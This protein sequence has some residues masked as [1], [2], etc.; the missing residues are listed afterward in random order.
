MPARSRCIGR[1][2][3]TT[4]RSLIYLGTVRDGYKP[5]TIFEKPAFSTLADV[6]TDSCVRA[7]DWNLI[8]ACSDFDVEATVFKLNYFDTL[9]K[10]VSMFICDDTNK[11]R[12]IR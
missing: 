7:I 2:S 4:R 6:I 9:G 8:S 10:I 5:G 12:E 3:F 1:Y 11:Q